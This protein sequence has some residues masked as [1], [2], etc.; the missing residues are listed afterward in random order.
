MLIAYLST[1]EVNQDLA[2]RLCEDGG[3]M[4][5]LLTFQEIPVNGSF[6]AVVYDWDYLPAELRPDTQAHLLTGPLAY[7]VAVHGYNLDEGLIDALR[8]NGVA[9]HR[10]LEAD[11]F[12]SLQR[13]A[14]RLHLAEK[15]RAEAE[16]TQPDSATG[17][18]MAPAV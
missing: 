4:L 14:E 6:D 16:A 8:R 17:Q 18:A 3:A 2:L 9:V 1:D 7:P 10:R 11:V 12:A 5:Y 13:A 15:R